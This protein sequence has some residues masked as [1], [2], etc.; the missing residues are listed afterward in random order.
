MVRL[1]YGVLLRAILLSVTFSVVNVSASDFGDATS[2]GIKILT[3]T[4]AGQ[5][6]PNDILVMSPPNAT[7]I[8]Y[9]DISL[10]TLNKPLKII[11]TGDAYGSPA[12]QPANLIVI[13]SNSLSLSSNIEIVGQTAD[14]L[15]ISP[16]TN[17]NLTCTRCVFK[18][19]GRIT[20]AAATA[21]SLSPT[22]SA[23]GNLS[24]T[25]NGTLTINSLEAPGVASLELIANSIVTTG[26]I[27]TQLRANFNSAGGY[28]IADN[29]GFVVGS[30]GVNIF[31]RNLIVNYENLELRNAIPS[32]N[33]LAINA[34]IN[35]ASIRVTTAS[36]LEIRADLST[37][38]DLLANTVYR[39]KMSAIIEVIELKTLATNP[40]NGHIYINGALKSDFLVALKSAGD[41]YVNREISGKNVDLTVAGKF[42]NSSLISSTNSTLV[43]DQIDN[44]GKFLSKNSINMVADYALQN[45]FGG[46]ILANE[47]SLASN[48]GVVRNGSQYPY[49]PA[50][51]GALVLRADANLDTTSRLS[52]LN[53]ADMTYAG[54][55]KVADLS[56]KIIGK[57]III[58]AKSNVENINPY[59]VYTKNSTDWANGIYF[60]GNAVDRVLLLADDKLS[61]R[62]G[63][64]VVNSSA[65]MGVNSPAAEK[66]FIVTAPNISNERYFTGVQGDVVNENDTIITST[67]DGT[68][69]S[70]TSG[71]SL[72][73]N[74][75]T[76]SPP[77]IIYS[78]A[79]LEFNLSQESGGFINNTA[80]FEALSDVYFRGLGKV[81]SVGL[82][83]EKENHNLVTTTV[84][85]VKNCNL[86]LYN[87]SEGASRACAAGVVTT[88]GPQP[89]ATLA[90]DMER[91]LF[92]VG[93]NLYGRKAE[94]FGRDH[95]V[96]DNMKAVIIKDYISSINAPRPAGS[97]N[98]DDY[99][100]AVL[101]SDGTQI[102]I[103]DYTKVL[104]IIAGEREYEMKQTQRS[105]PVWD[106]VVSALAKIKT[107][108]LSAMDAFINWLNS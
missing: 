80:Y 23:V 88:Q 4:S 37:Q 14:L 104:K 60:D 67:A 59:Y 90:T 97:A 87:S 13:K 17:S 63:Q 57:S 52:T 26:V 19:V 100:R 16:G 32:A 2:K 102:L 44:N 79:P 22:M 46:K 43:A 11:N 50:S 92:S 15:F 29:G 56:A 20:L 72:K 105:V 89:S 103:T 86:S 54:A 85:R 81:T 64:Y 8:S 45:R 33:N 66:K 75:Y 18:N 96:L 48:K 98:P 42:V 3:N 69:T 62:A 95:Q 25:S 74:L 91:T 39:N 77:G 68:I 6:G 38:S 94:F 27:N 5:P 9:N 1:V 12:M 36:P 55:T 40:S 70:N 21:S 107:A 84:T 65:I 58:D 73:A 35:S 101:S 76:Y 106:Q 24:N 47:I 78:F 51:E 61:I 93:G 49:K 30:G 41:I 108:F 83:L 53:I 71:S 34:K 99:S 31:A 7:G 82:A 10:L 28:D